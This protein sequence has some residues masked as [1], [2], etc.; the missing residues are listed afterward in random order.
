MQL[1]WPDIDFERERIRVRGS[2]SKGERT[3][4]VDMCQEVIDLLT[5]WKKQTC[6]DGVQLILVFGNEAGEARRE[7][8]QYRD[9]LREAQIDDFTWHEL[10]HY[11]PFRLCLV[12]SIAR[13]LW[14]MSDAG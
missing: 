7:V 12:T 6:R 1:T 14:G 3:R 2:T 11:V 10:R 9:V 4:Y 13:I 8:V 5:G